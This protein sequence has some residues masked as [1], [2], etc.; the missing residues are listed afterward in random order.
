MSIYL[1]KKEEEIM[2]V[3]WKTDGPLSAPVIK[4]MR[5]SINLNT[6]QTTLKKLI[7][8]QYIAVAGVEFRKKTVA[9]TYEPILQQSDYIKD[10][11]SNNG[12]M[13]MALNFVNSLAD[14]NELNELE[15]LIQKR[16]EDQKAKQ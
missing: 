8:K 12:S 3:F 9:K 1:S 11:L 14:E 5:P 2:E 6:I 7:K 16:K 15:A 13:A 4:E 10:W